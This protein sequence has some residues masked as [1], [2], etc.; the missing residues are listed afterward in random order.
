MKKLITTILLLLSPLAAAQSDEENYFYCGYTNI[1]GTAQDYSKWGKGTDFK[2]SEANSRWE[3]ITE[4]TFQYIYPDG[5]MSKK[6][7]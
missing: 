5:D 7:V 6:L 1:D 4:Y 2:Y 3:W